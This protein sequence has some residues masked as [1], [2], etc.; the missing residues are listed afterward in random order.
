MRP[1]I[2]HLA[3]LAICCL[4][5]THLRAENTK[6][7]I[8]FI[9]T[10]DH[11]WDGLTSAGNEQIRTPNLDKLCQAGTRFENAFVTLA[12]CS[13]SRAACLTGR[14]G[15]RNGVTAVGHAS[16]KKGEPTFARA[17][18]EAGYATG[19]AGKWHLGNSP[20]DCGFD[21]ASTC[22]SNGTWYNREFMI[23]GKKQVMP[24]FVDDVAVEQ[25]L[26]FLDQAAEAN[27]PFALWLCTQ[28]PHMDHKHTWPAKQEYKDQYIVGSMPLAAT[29]NDDLEGK[30]KYLAMSRSRTQALSYGYDD[31][32]NIRKHTRD[33]YASVQ[34]MDAAVGKFLDELERRGL[35]EST[36]IILMGDNGWML[37]EH[38]FTS[39]VLAYEES[40]RVP[41]A[42]VGPGQQPQVRSELVLNIDLTAMIYEL[43][44]LEVP[45]SLH[46]R[47]VLPIV[48]GKTISDWRTSFLYEA[49]T[50]QLGSK[51]LWAVRDAR[52]KY[53]E[54]DLGNGQV[55][56]ELYD[57]NS[58]AIEANNV[59]N[60]SRHDDRISQMERQLKAYLK[61]V[62]QS[63]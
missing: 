14:Y 29:W 49:P 62:V 42:V 37:G 7:N 51:P 45:R 11:R 50:P 55:F 1:S 56:R 32:E 58:D 3:A 25:S 13:P 63:D 6:P 39:K 33:Y 15:S 43:A 24:G 5:S 53:I 23:D 19:V 41:M 8:V 21:F 20:R 52:W 54:T 35:R 59:A 26:R 16:L 12:I 57:L 38:G 36:W 28:V 47:S 48:Q 44:G 27:K 61:R 46:G 18:K 22:W 2:L 60:E 17:L 34:Q 4:A 10:D 40:M 30:P 31:P 9:L